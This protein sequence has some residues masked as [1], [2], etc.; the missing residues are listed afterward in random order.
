MPTM[1]FLP[2]PLHAGQEVV[3]WPWHFEHN[4]FWGIL[5]LPRFRLTAVAAHGVIVL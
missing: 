2:V 1:D 5:Y 4:N 3:L